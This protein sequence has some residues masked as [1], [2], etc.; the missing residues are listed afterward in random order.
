MLWRLGKAYDSIEGDLWQN[1]LV[2][3]I[4]HK[5]EP[6][7]EAPSGGLSSNLIRDH[8]PAV[9]N[10]DRIGSIVE[11]LNHQ[12]VEIPL[13]T[14]VVVTGWSVDQAAKAPSGGVDIVI[15]GQPFRCVW[16]RSSRCSRPFRLSSVPEERILLHGAFYILEP[17]QA[18]AGRSN[19]LSRQEFFSGRGHA[20]GRNMNH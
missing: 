9:Y 12:G 10:I 14:T 17:G 18:P 11:P 20:N 5:C 4:D 8:A 3:W 19:D 1:D 2:A 7:T 6:A 16:L 15:D 13:D